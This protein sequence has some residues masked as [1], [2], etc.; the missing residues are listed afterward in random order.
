[1]GCCC[2]RAGSLSLDANMQHCWGVNAWAKCPNTAASDTAA[3]P[4]MLMWTLQAVRTCREQM[5]TSETSNCRPSRSAAALYSWTARQGSKAES[6]NKAFVW[7]PL[8]T[9]GTPGV[10]PTGFGAAKLTHTFLGVWACSTHG[11]V[12]GVVRPTQPCQVVHY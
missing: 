3:I 2:V 4:P 5:Q 1:L 12:E 10:K 6:T 11:H 7:E 9:I 8:V